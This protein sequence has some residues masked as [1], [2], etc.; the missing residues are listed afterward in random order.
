MSVI[1]SDFTNITKETIHMDNQNNVNS[2]DNKDTNVKTNQFLS[3]KEF[4]LIGRASKVTGDGTSGMN[5]HI[6]EH[7]FQKYGDK[8]PLFLISPKD[9][10]KNGETIKSKALCTPE[11]YS[12]V[13]SAIV[14][15]WTVKQ[16]DLLTRPTSS[17]RN[18]PE[19]AVYP[20][21]ANT[22]ANKLFL[23]QQK[24]A[25]LGDIRGSVNNRIKANKE[26]DPDA[27]TRTKIDIVSDMLSKLLK[28]DLQV[29][30]DLCYETDT[31]EYAKFSTNIQSALVIL[32]KINKNKIVNK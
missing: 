14:S 28:T 12:K 1:V 13:L 29:M 25:K 16:Q 32:K 30:K 21:E 11:E 3:D 2:I 6:G 20:Y 18:V 23:Q 10:K 4:S 19:F 7:F 26:G 15:K 8:A 5:R 24:T 22:K 9:K 31:F 17:L 27:L